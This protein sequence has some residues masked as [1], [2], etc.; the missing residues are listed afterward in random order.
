MDRTNLKEEVIKL[1]KQGKTYSEI[2]KNFRINTPKSTLCHWCKNV[3]LS[4]ESQNRIQK[5][6]FNNREKA[7]ATALAVNKAKREEYLKSIFQRNGHL[8]M[9]LKNKDIAKVV[10]SILYLCEGSKS[11]ERGSVMFGNSDPFIINLFLY[12]LRRCYNIYERKFRC[13]LQ[14]R[15]DQ[16]VKKLEKFW[17]KITNIPLSQFYKARIDSRTIGKKSKNLNYK[18]VCRIDYFSAEIA[19]ELMQISKI[20]HKGPIA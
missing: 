10:L 2:K 1:R 7:R 16:D 3:K 4:K 13:T 11:L 15:A 19:I 12:L 5:I 14:G 6:I 17:S 20:I 9:M 18:G 8:K